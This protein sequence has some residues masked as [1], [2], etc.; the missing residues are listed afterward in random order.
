MYTQISLQS[1]KEWLEE[2]VV[3]FTPYGDPRGR[4]K[5]G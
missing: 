2:Q 4:P 3:D 1:N 5:Y